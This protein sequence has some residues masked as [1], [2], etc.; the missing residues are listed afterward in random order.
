MGIPPEDPYV[1]PLY[2]QLT[3]TNANITSKLSTV[4]TDDGEILVFE[5]EDF[6]NTQREGVFLA[7][8]GAGEG[9][10]VFVVTQ[11][12]DVDWNKMVLVDLVVEEVE[13]KGEPVHED[14]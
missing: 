10:T 2:H 12:Q 3:S 8:K 4:S 6:N 14:M 5:N 7:D 9:G 11:F 13:D 1:P